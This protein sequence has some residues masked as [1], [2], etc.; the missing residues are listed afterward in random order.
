MSSV[1]R[2]AKAIRADLALWDGR[3]SSITR[4]DA[5]GGTVT[6]LPI[7]T[8]VDVLQVYGS[9]TNYTRSTINSA[10]SA[11]GSTPV[12]LLFSP[13][14][15]SIDANLTIPST[16]TCRIPRGCV[17]SVD[18]GKTLTFSGPIVA[19]SSSFYSGSGT[20]VLSAD[21]I[22]NGQTWI[23][24]TAN[25]VSAGITPS[26]YA[27]EPYHAR[28]YGV[29]GDGS[30]DDATA[31]QNWLTAIP[32]DGEG[33][34]PGATTYYK[35]TTALTRTNR[36]SIR[37][38]GQASRIHYT[39]SGV[40][41]TLN[42]GRFSKFEN[43]Y[44]TGTSSAAGG[45][46]VKAAQEGFSADAFFVD[47]FTSASGYA[48]RFSDSWDITIIGGAF[49]QSTTGILCDSTDLGQGGVVNTLTIEGTD[50]SACAIGVDYQSGNAL[51]LIGVD[52][53]NDGGVIAPVAGVEIGRSQSGTV[54]VGGVNILGCWFEGTG[55]GIRVGRSN[56]SSN[57]PRDVWLHGNYFGNSGNQIR[58]YVGTRVVIGA[59]QWGSGAV[60]IDAGVTQTTILNRGVT[61]T[62]N[63][64]AGE[65]RYFAFDTLVVDEITANNQF[66][67]GSGA[68][69]TRLLRGTATVDFG[70]LPD[71]DT[72]STTVT[73]TGAALGD[74]VLG[75]SHTVAV[76]G[77]MILAG[78]VTASNTVTVTLHNE[79]GG[80]VDLASGTV[81]A[82]VARFA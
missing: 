76:P 17:F 27:Y 12:T 63:S 50:C 54:H 71:G 23:A 10:L 9:G 4:L 20:T 1:I 48:I 68:Q 53:S 35:T 31:L 2:R 5:S 72:T 78:N 70:S 45:V 8:E 75:V 22:V 58:L 3:N 21:S 34:L 59:N 42:D 62:D 14:A 25:E 41:L 64:T 13:G 66:R 60:V 55:A 81:A 57:A 33:F 79:S 19:D 46:Y 61:I 47:G 11:I 29:T 67:I 51:T 37:G 38:E 73:V 74:V 65:T 7:G 32:T 52:F 49:R 30:T 44:L 36:L 15:W 26:N 18:S 6:G 28:R 24:R 77:G 43:W 16:V 39:G 69:M 80:T 40:A 56:T 82:V